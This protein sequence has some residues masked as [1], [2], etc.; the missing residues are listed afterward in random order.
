M[1]CKK[2]FFFLLFS[3]WLTAQ[4][5]WKPFLK[6][7]FKRISKP[8]GTDMNT[9]STPPPIPN[10]KTFFISIFQ[11]NFPFNFL[12]WLWHSIKKRDAVLLVIS[13]FCIKIQSHSNAMNTNPKV[14]LNAYGVQ[15]N[16]KHTPPTHN[17]T[18][19]ERES[20]AIL[21]IINVKLLHILNGCICGC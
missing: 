4:H 11:L 7:V 12:C 14:R 17:H 19:R 10:T 15:K 16:Q 18:H 3:W 5:V 9:K 1:L 20:T 21:I 8:H 2:K 13:D 6:E